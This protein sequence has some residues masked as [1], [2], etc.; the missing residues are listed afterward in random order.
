[1]EYTRNEYCYMHLIL[2]ACDSQTG[3]ASWECAQHYHGCHPDANVFRRLEQ[4]LQ[5]TG[6]R[7][8]PAHINAGHPWSVWM[9]HWRCH[10]C[11]CGMRTFKKIMCYHNRIGTIP[12][13]V[14]YTL[15][16]YEQHPYH[17]LQNQYQLPVDRPL[18]MQFYELL[19]QQHVADV[20]YENILWTDKV[21]F[22]CKEVFQR[23]QWSCV[24]MG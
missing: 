24:V 17:Y 14:P 23:P 15:H 22:T 20:L 1:M 13:I 18:W 3:I 6:S 5:E 19:H 10:N 4:C 9:R 12:C 16:D 8:P 2:S 11:C 21:C 7:T